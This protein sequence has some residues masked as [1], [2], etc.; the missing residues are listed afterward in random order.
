MSE[1][2][3]KVLLVEDNEYDRKLFLAELSRASPPGFEVKAAGSIEEALRT[4]ADMTIDLV[5][6]DLNLPDSAGLES[7]R[8]IREAAPDVPIVVLTG[9]DDETLGIHAVAMGAQ[10]YIVKGTFLGSMLP[11]ALR[12]AIERA[13]R[14]HDGHLSRPNPPVDPNLAVRLERLTAREREVLD[15]LVRG[16]TLKQV[17]IALEVSIQ[18]A[19]K[20]RARILQKFEVNGDV[21]LVRLILAAGSPLD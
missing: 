1:R 21:E 5:A 7:C 6:L 12:L 14:L 20:H 18:T 4:L 3:T 2:P 17:A 11:R 13:Q 8:Q 19:A 15:L 16:T 10:D 9:L